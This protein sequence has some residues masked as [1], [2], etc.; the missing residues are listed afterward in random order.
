M[1]VNTNELPRFLF[2]IRLEAANYAIVERNDLVPKVQE[3]LK[4]WI[5]KPVVTEY[6]NVC[7]LL[8]HQLLP[9]IRNVAG[10]V[11]KSTTAYRRLHSLRTRLRGTTDGLYLRLE[12]NLVRRHPV[13]G[14]PPVH[15]RFTA[16]EDR[17]MVLENRVARALCDLPPDPPM[18]RERI[19]EL[20]RELQLLL[21]QMRQCEARLT[22]FGLVED[23]LT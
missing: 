11:G 2:D 7:S 14:R 23:I 12:C 18:N 22:P 16:P 6:G 1:S 19:A 3:V 15:I 20:R 21:D 13:P 9:L 17:L 8:R 4:G 10:M 5:G